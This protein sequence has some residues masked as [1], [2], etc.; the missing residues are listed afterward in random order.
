LQAPHPQPAK[1]EQ[2]TDRRTGSSDH[3]HH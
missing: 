1:H 3:A 2:W